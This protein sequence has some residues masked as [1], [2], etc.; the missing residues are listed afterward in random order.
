LQVLGFKGRLRA[1]V[2]RE[3]LKALG[4]LVWKVRAHFTDNGLHV[5]AVNAENVAMVIL[6]VP[7]KSFES[8][9]G[10]NL[11]VGLDLDRLNESIKAFRA[12]EIVEVAINESLTL[13]NGKITYRLP[14]INPKAI[15]RDPKIP[16]LNLPAKIVMSVGEFKKIVKLAE[17]IADDVVLESDGDSFTIHAKGDL[18]S[19]RATLTETK[20]IEFSGGK[21]RSMFGVYYLKSFCKAANDKDKLTIY[22]GTDYPAKF[23]LDK[24][25]FRVEYILAPRIEAEN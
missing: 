10:Q 6:D 21:A 18:E 25:D 17:E 13:K 5:R 15:R 11:T 7:R 23:V 20:L 9:S 19:M 8:Y 14:L 3:A 22:L 4:V 24:S 2:L 12:D 16:E 1:S